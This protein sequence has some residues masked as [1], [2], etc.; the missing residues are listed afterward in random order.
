MIKLKGKANHLS[1]ELHPTPVDG[2][3]K[4]GGDGKIKG[5]HCIEIDGQLIPK[6]MNCI[7]LENPGVKIFYSLRWFKGIKKK[8]IDQE[9]RNLRKLS[10]A[11][12]AP[13]PGAMTKVKLDFTY[14]GK[15]VK[16]TATAIEVETVD[17]PR[18]AVQGLAIGKP[19]DWSVVDHHNHSPAGFLR[20]K[21]EAKKIIKKLCLKWDGS[22]KI[23]DVLW[24]R[25]KEKWMLVDCS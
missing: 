12:I 3:H 24:D 15:H 7:F 21:S 25:K 2:V 14:M 20:F 11:G 6:G 5:L 10:R 23:G 22:L 19:Y 4:T 1:R 17:Y 16:R 9:V 8:F 13:K 18:E